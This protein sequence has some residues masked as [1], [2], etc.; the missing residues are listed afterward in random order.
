MLLNFTTNIMTE[1]MMEFGNSNVVSEKSMDGKCLGMKWITKVY[2]PKIIDCNKKMIFQNEL[3]IIVST[4]MNSS[5]TVISV[6]FIH[7]VCP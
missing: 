6:S 1:S 2:V 3:C 5:T 4:R 7:I